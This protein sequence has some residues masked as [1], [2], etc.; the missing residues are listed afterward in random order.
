MADFGIDLQIL[1][2]RARAEM[3]KGPVIG[4]YRADP[5]RVTALRNEALA[6]GIVRV[7]R[8]EQHHYAAKGLDAEPVTEEFAE[9]ADEGQD[10]HRPAARIASWAARRTGTRRRRPGEALRVHDM[11]TFL[12]QMG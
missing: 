9:H 10:A 8:Y 6:T 4:E 5:D 12:G 2:E 1:R 3:D 11:I 7:L